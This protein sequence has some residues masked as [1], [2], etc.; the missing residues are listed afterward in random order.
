MPEP[1]R[2][3]LSW[4]EHLRLAAGIAVEPE[5]PRTLVSVDWDFFLP[6]P[7]LGLIS[8]PAAEMLAPVAAFGLDEWYSAARQARIW[9]ELAELAGLAGY[10]AAELFR[11]DQRLRPSR[12]AATLRRRFRFTAV[13]LADS[14]AWGAHAALAASRRAGLAID[15]VSFDAHHDCGYFNYRGDNWD[16]SQARAAERPSCDDW[17]QAGL[18]HGAIR[19]AT[20]VYPDW[21]GLRELQVHP[22]TLP[23]ELVEAVS[24]TSW[25]AWLAQPPLSSEPTTAELLIVRSS[26]YSPPYGDN[27]KRF[28]ELAGELAPGGYR[29]LDCERPGGVSFGP[30]DGCTPR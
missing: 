14:H 3:R 10:D 23:G 21:K 2:H 1:Y 13:S 17:V 12:F 9:S 4:S 27:D 25:T 19:R 15:L 20:I 26:S 16:R 28:L 7:N 11:P 24:P 22:W 30:Y 5:A 8:E 29:C 6:G 18:V